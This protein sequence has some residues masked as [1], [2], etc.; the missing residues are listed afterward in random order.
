MS[1]YDSL[2]SLLDYECLLFCCDW[3]GSDLRI[4]HLRITRDE[5]QMMYHFRINSTLESKSK[6]K[7]KL[8][9]DRRSVGQSVLVSSTPLGLTTRN[10]RI[11]AWVWVILRLTVSRP[12]SLGIKHPSGAYDQFFITVSQL[13]VCWCGA[14]SLTTGRVCR[15]Q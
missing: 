7:S 5:W 13:R 9:Y 14:L 6:S 15:L 8:C 10:S 2:H 11:W 12:V 1:V 4:R 3:P